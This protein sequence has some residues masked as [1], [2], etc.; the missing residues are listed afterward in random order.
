MRTME[1]L[2]TLEYYRRLPEGFPAQLLDG[3]LVSEAAPGFDHQDLVGQIYLGLVAVVERRRVALSP[4]DVVI[5][6]LNVLQPDVCLLRHPPPPGLPDVGVPLLAFEVLS[7]ATRRR[8]VTVK[9]VKLLAAGTEEVWLVDPDAR[10]IAVRT[11][12]GTRVFRGAQE[13]RSDVVPDVRFV[14]D[15]LFG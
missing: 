9:A 4:A 10:T 13:A 5:D 3:C 6:R 14:P 2:F 1:S 12:E 15:V 8:D 11:T 7:P